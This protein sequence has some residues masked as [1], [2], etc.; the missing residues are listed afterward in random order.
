MEGLVGK[1]SS[2]KSS[3]HVLTRW[4]EK[5]VVWWAVITEFAGFSDRVDLLGGVKVELWCPR[6]KN[7]R[8][9]NGILVGKGGENWHSLLGKHQKFACSWYRITCLKDNQI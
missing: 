7:W 2:K 1:A 3:I 4:M 8:H 5:I 9:E 6:K